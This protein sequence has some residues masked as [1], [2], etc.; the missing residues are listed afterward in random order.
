MSV[1]KVSNS[2]N[3]FEKLHAIHKIIICLVLAI[4]VYLVADIKNINPLTRIMIG[5][6]TFSLC[7]IILSWITF[8]ITTPTEIRKQA[9][10]QDSSRA[11]IFTIILISTFAS[12]LAVFLLLISKDKATEFLDIPIAVSGMAFSWF[13]VHTVFTMRYA[14]I[15]YEDNEAKSDEPAGGLTFPGDN[16]PDYLDFA[17]FSFVLGMTF[18]VSDIKVTSKRLR[19][20]AMLHGI[21]SFAFNTV[22]VALTINVIAGLSK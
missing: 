22:I 20:I 18:Q 9:G 14:H 8:T 2:H 6:N 4:V 15:F 1:K 3:A 13:L 5:W 17:Y 16:K 11:V 10:V 12:F 19:K 7:M 21:L